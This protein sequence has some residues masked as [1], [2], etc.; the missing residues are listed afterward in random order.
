MPSAKFVVA[1]DSRSRLTE[2]FEESSGALA[3]GA[4]RNRSKLPQQALP[5]NG[6]ELIQD[7]LPG[8]S[9]KAHWHSSGIKPHGCCHRRNDDGLQIT[10]HFIRRDDQARTGLLDLSAVRRI[11]A[12]EPDLIP[13]RRSVH[14]FHSFRSNSLGATVS[15]RRSTFIPEQIERNDSYQPCRERRS[16]QL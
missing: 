6:A 3:G 11:K 10:V 15:S 12:Y 5:I 9:L 16:V 1:T 2:H 13:L 8:F 7:D 4:R 14:H